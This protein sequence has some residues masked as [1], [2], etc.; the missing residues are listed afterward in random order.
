M[1]K[2]R[3][4]PFLKKKKDSFCWQ[5]RI[6][7]LQYNCYR[8]AICHNLVL[9][10]FLSFGPIYRRNKCSRLEVR[11]SVYQSGPI[12]S[13]RLAANTLGTMIWS[14]ITR[15]GAI[16][17]IFIEAGNQSV[18]SLFLDRLLQMAQMQRILRDIA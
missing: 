5:N 8:S 3:L 9:L 11:V 16:A 17:A 13:C 2:Q 18:F 15:L 14:G 10:T 6:S 4:F 1:R 12:H 7:F